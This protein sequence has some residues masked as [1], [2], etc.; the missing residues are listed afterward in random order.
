MNGADPNAPMNLTNA[1][2]L[3]DRCIIALMIYC[4]YKGTKC[5]PPY[6][7]HKIEITD[8]Q[9][10]QFTSYWEKTYAQ[11]TG[12]KKEKDLISKITPHYSK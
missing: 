10:K 7:Y 5:K 11:D 3:P 8:Y 12:A 2:R 6:A 4:K 1:D 9:V